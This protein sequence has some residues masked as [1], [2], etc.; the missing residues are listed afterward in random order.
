MTHF[1]DWP[2]VYMKH[3]PGYSIFKAGMCTSNEGVVVKMH[4]S[5]AKCRICIPVHSK[6][7]RT[8][9]VLKSHKNEKGVCI[10]SDVCYSV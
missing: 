9:W 5:L 4:S 1:D 7:T 6:E 2:C 8:M 10:E 3:E